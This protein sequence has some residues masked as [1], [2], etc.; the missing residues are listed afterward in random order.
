MPVL[1]EEVIK[2]D[3]S[4]GNFAPVYILFGNDSYL[5]KFYFDKLCDSAY[6]GDPFFNLL[7]F[8]SNSNLQDVYDAVMQYPM[9]ADSKCVAVTDF[10]SAIIG[11]CI[12]AS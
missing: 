4:T 3:L 2:K 5:K 11:Y 1:F 7:K 8:E 10:E 9:M 12:T 6:G